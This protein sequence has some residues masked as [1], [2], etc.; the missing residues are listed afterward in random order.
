MVEQ[1]KGGGSW[2]DNYHTDLR[3]GHESICISGIKSKERA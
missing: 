2:Q 1:E 3:T